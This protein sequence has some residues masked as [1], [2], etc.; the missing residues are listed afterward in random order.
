MQRFVIQGRLPGLNEMIAAMNTHRYRGAELKKKET[1]RCAWSVVGHRIDK[2]TSP[3]RIV[4]TW[5]EPNARRDLDNV[6]AGVKYILDGLMEAG[7]LPSDG[8]KYV[9]GIEHRFPDPDPL[10]PRIEVSLEAI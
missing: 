1:R 5:V 10:N 7:K 4:V 6:A 8:R 2:V 9:R 3:I